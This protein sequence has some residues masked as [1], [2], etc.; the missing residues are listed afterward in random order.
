VTVHGP[1]LLRRQGSFAFPA[2]FLSRNGSAGFFLEDFTD[3][4]IA[5]NR[6]GFGAADS[7]EFRVALGLR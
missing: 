3:G 7:P 1:R 4:L 2:P 6:A 5:I